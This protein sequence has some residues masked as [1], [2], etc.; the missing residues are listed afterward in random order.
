MA[1][2][3]GLVLAGGLSRR[4]GRDKALLPYEGE[5]LAA[6]VAGRLALIC[7]DVILAS[8]DGRRLESLGWPQVADAHRGSG[9]LA[10]IVAGLE[11][12]HHPLVA[13]VAADMPDASPG[14]LLALAQRWTGQVAVVPSISGRLEPLHAVWWQGA[15]PALRARLEAGQRSLHSALSALGALVVDASALDPSLRF[16]RNLN[17]PGDVGSLPA[18]PLG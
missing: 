7:D 9:P 16:A 17:E 11:G 14:V 8:G 12:A 15:A 6:R 4:M 2:L 5:P 18:A 1:A 10:G 3:S 13:V